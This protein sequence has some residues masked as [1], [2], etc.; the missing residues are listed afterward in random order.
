[1][2][3]DPARTGRSVEAILAREDGPIIVIAPFVKAEALRRLC[4]E[5][6]VPVTLY[7]RWMP[8]EVAAGISDLEVLDLILD[9]GGQIRLHPRLHAKAYLRGSTALVGSANTTLRGLGFRDPA[10][11]ELVVPVELPNPPITALLGFLERTT[12]VATQA[13][14]DAVA[15][16]ASQ[17]DLARLP[18]QADVDETYPEEIEASPL[19][20]FRDPQVA[21][22]YYTR[23]E[24][25]DA[26]LVRQLLRSLAGIGVPPWIK[27][28]AAFRAAV[29]AGMRQGIHGRVLRECNRLP[30]YAAISRYRHIMNEAGV[31][32]PADRADE[33]WRTFCYWAQEFVP[34]IELRPTQVGF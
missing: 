4:A 14:R 27:T 28:P 7:T 29:G 25:Y 30:A 1:M 32:V 19:I 21:W 20:E 18:A 3:W 11:V 13:D 33:S 10:A 24:D 8:H 22:A 5:S 12:P 15:E 23:P 2:E 16:R 31:D 17:V 34:E 26:V 9:T 6:D